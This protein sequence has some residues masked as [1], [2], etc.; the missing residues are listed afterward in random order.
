MTDYDKGYTDGFNKANS[1]IKPLMK[2][3]HDCVYSQGVCNATDELIE[4]LEKRL[5]WGDQSYSMAIRH[6]IEMAKA[7]KL[8]LAGLE[9]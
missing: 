5:D 1:Q 9:D 7:I 8:E 6:C 2:K 3:I 4:W